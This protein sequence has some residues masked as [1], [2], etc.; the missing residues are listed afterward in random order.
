MTL[1]LFKMAVDK[2]ETNEFFLGK[3]KYFL[4][5]REDGS[6]SYLMQDS[7]AGAAFIKMNPANV[8][9]FIESLSCFIDRSSSLVDNVDAV[10][11]SIVS[12][13]SIIDSG[14]VSLDDIISASNGK[15]ESAI[16]NAYLIGCNE[17]SSKKI[18]NA[19]VKLIKNRSNRFHD[20]IKSFVGDINA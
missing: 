13:V 14:V 3:G 5:N 19:Y 15:L 17:E 4:L 11:Q 10:W 9:V 2:N 20:Y 12:L 8:G 7:T 6:H 1:N 16:K 18:I